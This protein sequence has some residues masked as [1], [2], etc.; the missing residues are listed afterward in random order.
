MV[1]AALRTLLRRSDQFRTTLRSG[2]HTEVNAARELLR[3]SLVELHNLGYWQAHPEQ[4]RCY[5]R[6]YRAVDAGTLTGLESSSGP[7]RM[8]RYSP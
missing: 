2:T 3:L 1:Q 5:M 4:L 7:D 8:A 6:L